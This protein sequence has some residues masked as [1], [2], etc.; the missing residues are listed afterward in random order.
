MKGLTDLLKQSIDL[1]DTPDTTHF[2]ID[3]GFAA[4]PLFRFFLQQHYPRKKISNTEFAQATSLG[5]FLHLKAA[6]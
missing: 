2:Y 6:I 4:N 5:A 1:V 3:G